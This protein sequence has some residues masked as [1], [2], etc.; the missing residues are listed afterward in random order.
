MSV[1]LNVVGFAAG[2]LLAIP[3]ITGLFPGTI[4]PRSTIVVNIGVGSSGSEPL[5][6][7]D[8]KP[9]GEGLSGSTPEVALF[10][11]KGRLLGRSR[12][13][14]TVT[15]GGSMEVQISSDPG[16][17]GSVVPEYVQLIH[18]PGAPISGDF[19]DP[20]CVSW[21]TTI[22]SSSSNADFRSWNAATA[23]ACNIPWYPSVSHFGGVRHRFQPPCFWLDG[24]GVY[25]RQFPKA[26]SARLFDFFFPGDP[27]APDAAAMAKQW[28]ERPDT[29]CEAPAR[30]RF[31]SR[32]GDCIPTYPPDL[33]EVNREVLEREGVK[34][35][36]YEVVKEWK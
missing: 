29:L 27:G 4:P 33:A 34:R 20:I 25:G 14:T 6:F 1:A 5:P 7:R 10:D 3:G 24:G 36:E 16:G 13:K 32:A 23:R 12:P 18:P 30:Q 2:A 21:I 11:I 15:E 35:K 8:V 22:S 28:S 19:A 26:M 31:Y 9:G 17:L